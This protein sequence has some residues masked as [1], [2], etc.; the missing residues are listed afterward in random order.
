MRGTFRALAVD[1]GDNLSFDST[2]IGSSPESEG[3]GEKEK[4][5]VLE[6]EKKREADMRREEKR[7]EARRGTTHFLCCSGGFVSIS[8][9]GV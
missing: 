9:A 1:G 6:D 8:G 7:A 4:R 2:K 5:R 3:I